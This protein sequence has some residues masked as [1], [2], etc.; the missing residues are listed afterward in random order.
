LVLL[1]LDDQMDMPVGKGAAHAFGQFLQQM[2]KKASEA[3][4]YPDVRWCRGR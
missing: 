3:A 2:E 4:A 1:V